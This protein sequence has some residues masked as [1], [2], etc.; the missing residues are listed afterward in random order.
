[1]GLKADLEKACIDSHGLGS[2]N[3]AVD[4]GNCSNLAQAQTDAIVDWI[5]AQTFRITEMKAILEIEK[6]KT[7]APTT[8]NIQP[9]VMA[10]AGIP[11][12]AGGIPGPGSTTGPGML[13]GTNKGV[14]VPKISFK[15]SGG[16]GGALIT[17]GYAY[18]GDNPVGSSPE[19]KTKV[20][21]LRRDLTEL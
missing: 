15:K 13:Q 19:T 10:S 8:A 9:T 6:F 11:V 14:L 4:E 16:M 5:T 17:K 7:T 3:Q 18:I 2:T 21:L 1:V 20:Q 12:V